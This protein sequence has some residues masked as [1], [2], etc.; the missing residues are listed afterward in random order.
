MHKKL[1]LMLIVLLIL[2]VALAAFLYLRTVNIPVLE[3]KGVIA[4]KERQLIFIALGLSAIVVIPVFTL[5]FV[6]AWRY[7]SANT[8]AKYSP[9]LAGSRVAE[10]MWWLIL[11]AL[12]LVLSVVTW[13]SS[14]ALDPYKPLVS[15]VKPL[16]IQ[17]VPL[18]WKWLFVYPDQHIATVNF[19]QFPQNTPVDFK[20]TSD[21]VMNSFWVPALGGQIYAMPGMSTQL[22]LMADQTGNFSGMSANISGKGF[23]GMVFTAKA[24]TESDFNTWVKYVKK[25]PNNLT[26][27]AYDALAQP[28]ENNQLTFYA[29]AQNNLYDT[30]VLK[31]MTP[32]QS[33]PGPNNNS[34]APMMAMPA[35]Q[36]MNMRN[37]VM[38]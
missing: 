12:I 38:Q 19:V 35:M 22:H 37:M 27:S 1:R 34:G 6:F 30:I 29:S 23:S 4:E 18:D 26:Q 16:T 32:M 20:I 10:T 2:G 36:G 7:R 8:K 17:V 11:S 5:L 25:S 33:A 28:S 31:Y 24:S 3:P 15:N 14:H 13:N 9:N 21:A